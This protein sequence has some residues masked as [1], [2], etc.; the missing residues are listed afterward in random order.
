ME[1]PPR[2]LP[3]NFALDVAK[4]TVSIRKK[5][6]D[7]SEPKASWSFLPNADRHFGDPPTA[8]NGSAI[9]FFLVT[10]SWR[11]KKK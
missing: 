5:R 11:S 3:L 7:M 2:L 6:E 10:F 1:G 4:M 8:G 9:A